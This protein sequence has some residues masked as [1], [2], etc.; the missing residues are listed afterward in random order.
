MKKDEGKGAA[1]DFIKNILNEIYINQQG[2][3]VQIS[4]HLKKIE[5]YF[6]SAKVPV[7]TANEAEMLFIGFP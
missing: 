3:H 7:I 4:I 1:A 5:E 2:F 6:F